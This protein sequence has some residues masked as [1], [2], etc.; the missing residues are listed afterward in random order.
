MDEEHEQCEEAMKIL[1]SEQTAE[2]LEAVLDVF[3]AHFEHEEQMLDT[4]LYADQKDSAS[5]GG[6]SVDSSAR[7]SHF[8][9][10]ERILRM[11]KA[12]LAKAK[13][14]KS[15]VPASF[16]RSVVHD[17]DQHASKY[18]GNYGE[19]MKAEMAAASAGENICMLA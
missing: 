17:F 4:Y 16:V 12:E 14:P 5:S 13:G 3:E 11:I 18:D 7:K 6:F 9:D 10:H 15:L 2:A 8:A 1:C 19:R